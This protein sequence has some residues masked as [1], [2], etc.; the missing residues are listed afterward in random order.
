[1]GILILLTVTT[2]LAVLSC[3][4]NR[5]P[6]SQYVVPPQRPLPVPPSSEC[7][8]TAGY[9]P[10]YGNTI[11]ALEDAGYGT[12]PSMHY[13]ALPLEEMGELK[14]GHK[15]RHSISSSFYGVP[16]PSKMNL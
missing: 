9:R 13:S 8:Q 16:P 12:D 7:P 3:R 15:T 1:M 5:H 10:P 4:E 2:V 14:P 11:K 6:W